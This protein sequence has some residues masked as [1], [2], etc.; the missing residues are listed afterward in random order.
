MLLSDIKNY[1]KQKTHKYPRS[2]HQANVIKILKG[3]ED[4]A[5]K[6]QKAN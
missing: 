3:E 5:H 1:I 4:K 2:I 6:L